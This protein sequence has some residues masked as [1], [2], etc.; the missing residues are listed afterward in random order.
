M[1]ST[2]KFT[3]RFFATLF[4]A[5]LLIGCSKDSVEGQPGPQGI[6]GEQGP[7]GPKGD[8]GEQGEPGSSTGQGDQGEPGEQGE[9]G[10]TGPQGPKG[11]PGQDGQDG[12]DGANGEDGETGTANVI[13]SEWFD[14]DFDTDIT[15]GFDV[16]EV[17]APEITQEVLDTSVIFV[18]A[19]SN[20]GA[21]FLLPVSFEGFLDENYWAR[22]INA[23]TLQIGVEGMNGNNNIGEPFLNNLFRYIIIPGGV[24]S[25]GKSVTSQDYTKMSYEEIADLFDIPAE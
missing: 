25:S 10:A 24:P 17:D 11:D 8:Q 4:V 19:R 16:F 2:M 7:Q 21:Y 5:S 18:F 12:E 15:N 6:Q 20:T 3:R 1:K 13:Y 23:G 22:I 9:Q 14:G